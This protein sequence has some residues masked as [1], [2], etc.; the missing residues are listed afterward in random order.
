MHHVWS[1]QSPFTENHASYHER[2]LVVLLYHTLTKY[3]PTCAFQCD[4]LMSSTWHSILHCFLSINLLATICHMGWARN[5]WSLITRLLFQKSLH[6]GI[7][8]QYRTV[9]NF[10]D[11]I[12]QIEA[13]F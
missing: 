9:A 12:G 2:Q 6:R 8:H 5:P 10:I 7:F 1:N 11:K 13:S 3:I 4:T